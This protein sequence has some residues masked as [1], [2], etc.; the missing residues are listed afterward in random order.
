MRRTASRIGTLALVA[1]LGGA[2][3]GAATASDAEVPARP[4]TTSVVPPPP[5][6]VQP[7]PAP[8]RPQDPPELSRPSPQPGPDAVDPSERRRNDGMPRALPETPGPLP[9]P[10]SSVLPTPPLAMPHAEGER[11]VP[12]LCG[13]TPPAGR[14][15][16]EVSH[17]PPGH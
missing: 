8:E 2:G 11:E 12:E 10:R 7:L 6:P 4:R 5:G 13:S 3:L 16:C 1:V 15:D 14:G 9:M 17:G